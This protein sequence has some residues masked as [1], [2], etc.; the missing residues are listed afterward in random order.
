MLGEKTVLL[1]LLTAV[2]AALLPAT[3]GTSHNSDSYGRTTRLA[4]GKTQRVVVLENDKSIAITPPCLAHPSMPF[5]VFSL[6][7]LPPTLCKKSFLSFF[8]LFS[9]LATVL[10][11]YCSDCLQN[12][13]T[14][15]GEVCAIHTIFHPETGEKTAERWRCLNGR[16]INL[17]NISSPLVS[18]ECCNTHDFCNYENYTSVSET[19]DL[20][21][22]T[23]NLTG[24]YS[25]GNLTTN[26]TESEDD[27]MPPETSTTH[28]PGRL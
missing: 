2:L 6:L 16:D 9:L 11:C 7:S 8:T 27:G 21:C 4:G 22:E 14:C 25:A 28:P 19:G 24:N 1:L 20:G 5:E 15:S 3:A 18:V 17:C 12:Q 26:C 23:G 13:T 10:R